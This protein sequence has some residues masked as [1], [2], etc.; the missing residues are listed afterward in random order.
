MI[1][2]KQ[3]QWD[4]AMGQFWFCV[5]SRYLCILTSKLPVQGGV[6]PAFVTDIWIMTMVVTRQSFRSEPAYEV[7]IDVIIWVYF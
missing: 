4:Q 3:D 5:V 7:D 1:V 6:G 2:L